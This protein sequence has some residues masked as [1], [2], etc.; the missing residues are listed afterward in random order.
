MAS[1]L[2][3]KLHLLAKTSLRANHE[4]YRDAE[5]K[6]SAVGVNCDR[7]TVTEFA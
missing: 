4:P 2:S 1:R 3:F 5:C 7:F 6:G